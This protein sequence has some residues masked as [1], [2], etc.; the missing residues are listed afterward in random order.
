M[1]RFIV[2]IGIAALSLLGI[3]PA[4][5]TVAPAS[6]L[7]VFTVPALVI[8]PGGGMF[9]PEHTQG[10]KDFAGH[11]PDVAADANLVGLHPGSRQL[12]FGLCM[13]AVETKKDFTRANGCTDLFPVFGAPAG[14]CI[15]SVSR[16]IF[17]QLHYVDDNHAVDTFGPQ[18]P[19]S[20]VE[21]WAV[22]GDTSGNEAGSRTGVRILT[23]SF[24]VTTAPC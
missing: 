14:Q 5:A 1:R 13:D 12:S 18:V 3:S 8:P 23:R 9:I 19:N 11:G 6:Q 2:F 15:L 21:Q 10:D 17:E 7:P 24:T 20:F 16:G 4:G 22:V